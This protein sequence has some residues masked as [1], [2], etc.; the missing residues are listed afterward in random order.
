MADRPCLSSRHTQPPHPTADR[1]GHVVSQ[2]LGAEATCIPRFDGE[3]LQSVKVSHNIGVN[4]VN[5]QTRARIEWTFNRV[6]EGRW[7]ATWDLERDTVVIER[8]PETAE[9]LTRGTSSVP[10]DDADRQTTDAT[11]RG[12]HG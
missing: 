4:I 12:D 5:P 1:V 10:S 6:V 7:R 3:E 8:H 2:L 11:W 9:T